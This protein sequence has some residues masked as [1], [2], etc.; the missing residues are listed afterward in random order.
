VTDTWNDDR[1]N[2]LH[3]YYPAVRSAEELEQLAGRLGVTVTA[4]K[5]K[6]KREGLRRPR[7]G[8]RA[9]LLREEDDLVILGAVHDSRR[10]DVALLARQ[11]NTSPSAVQQRYEELQRRRRARVGDI[12]E[13]TLSRAVHAVSCGDAVDDVAAREHADADDLRLKLIGL[14]V[15]DQ[16]DAEERIT[17]ADAAGRL[18]VSRDEILQ[19]VLRGELSATSPDGSDR[20]LPDGDW[21]TSDVRLG[22]MLVAMPQRLNLKRADPVF[23]LRLAVATGARIGLQLR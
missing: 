23:V 13:R 5:V 8:S 22:A 20:G 10:P 3:R 2:I 17:I 19:A 14:G 9:R 4:M 7:Q 6:A 15:R 21:L 12:P 16:I 11:L 1:L 18:G